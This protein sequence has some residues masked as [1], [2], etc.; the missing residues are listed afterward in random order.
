MD[1]ENPRNQENKSGKQASFVQTFSSEDRADPQKTQFLPSSVGAS[2]GF[3][4]SDALHAEKKI[5]L[6]ISTKKYAC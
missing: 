4:G 5:T 3:D 1:K 2:K 6:R